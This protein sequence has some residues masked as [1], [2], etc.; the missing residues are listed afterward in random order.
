MAMNSVTILDNSDGTGLNMKQ[1]GTNGEAHV[2][3]QAAA[4]GT[5]TN[6]EDTTVTT[7]VESS[8]AIANA[9]AIRIQ[10][11][12]AAGTVDV[13]NNPGLYYVFNSSDPAGDL[14]DATIRKF[15]KYGTDVVHA[16]SSDDPLTLFSYKGGAGTLTNMVLNYE[17]KT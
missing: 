12:I 16:F 8:G 13:T 17:Y 3:T 15:L 9:N 7:S 6:R 14:A 1:K 11:H 5:L 4:P 10:W 2:T